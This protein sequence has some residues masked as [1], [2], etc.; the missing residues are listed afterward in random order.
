MTNI[1]QSSTTYI[2]PSS[3]RLVMNKLE[4]CIVCSDLIS[5]HG[6]QEMKK[7]YKEFVRV[8]TLGE[9]EE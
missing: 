8:A 4:T 2:Y 7:C 5:D 1:E 6:R 9:I 3:Y